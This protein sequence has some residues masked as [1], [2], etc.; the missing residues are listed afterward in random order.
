[1]ERFNVFLLDLSA[2][3]N[4]E[5][6]EVV[7]LGIYWQRLLCTGLHGHLLQI[8]TPFPLTNL[9]DFLAQLR[10]ITLC[11]RKEIVRGVGSKLKDFSLESVYNIGSLG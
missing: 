8:T 11:R 9:S 4:E 5:V 7:F 6:V 1:M 10:Q 2:V 3:S